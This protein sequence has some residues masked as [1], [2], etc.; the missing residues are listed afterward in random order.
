[1]KRETFVQIMSALLAEA[2]AELLR[3]AEGL[4]FWRKREL[5]AELVTHYS[6]GQE[7]TYQMPGG[8]KKS[9]AIHQLNRFSVSVRHPHPIVG[10]TVDVVPVERIIPEEEIPA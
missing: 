9:G 5:R 6:V 3:E 1:M 8:S 2:D 7:I 10:Y 4:V